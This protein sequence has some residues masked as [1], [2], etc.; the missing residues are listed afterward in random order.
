MSQ[1]L[2]SYV[3]TAR[4]F[5]ILIHVPRELIVVVVYGNPVRD[6]ESHLASILLSN[7]FYNTGNDYHTHIY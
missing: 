6:L 5:T 2:Y 7:R 1:L 4:T 3:P